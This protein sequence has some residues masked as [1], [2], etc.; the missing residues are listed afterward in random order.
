MSLNETFF[1]IEN[2]WNLLFF[3]E[4]PNGFA[5]LIIGEHPNSVEADTSIWHQ[6]PERFS[7]IHSLLN[8]G[9]TVFTSEL[10]GKHWGSS[11]AVDYM[12]QLYHLIYKRALLNKKVHLIAEG[13]GALVT[14][15][16]LKRRPEVIRSAFFINP[17]MYLDAFAKQEE[18][19]KL[20]YKRFIREFLT[21][22]GLSQD[23][24]DPSV[25]KRQL[26]LNEFNECPPLHI[27]HDVT[28]KRYPFEQHSR[29]FTKECEDNNIPITL[30]LHG[31]SKSYSSFI[32][33]A[34]KFFKKTEM[35]L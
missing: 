11:R 12:E 23:E 4:R 24:L 25:F 2:Q 29:P 9:Y 16:L 13:S 6:H 7:F 26:S 28:N 1:K 8:E 14:Q 35:K 3:P 15:G 19:N 31:G 20:Y 5:V 21:A 17:C 10:F 22:H 34:L 30:S 33:P 27:I 18:Q 32:H